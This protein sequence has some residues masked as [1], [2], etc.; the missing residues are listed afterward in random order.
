MSQSEQPRVA[1]LG[2]GRMGA[3]M[4]RHVLAAG[5]ELVVWNRDAAKAE[6]LREAGAQVAGAPAAAVTGRDVVVLMLADPDAVRE[7]LFGP[8]GVAAGAKPGTLVI[9][10]STIGP[11]ASREVAA[12]LADHGVRYV[13]APVAGSVKPATDG[14]LG[15]LAGGSDEDFAAARPFL[16]LW[17]EEGKVQHVGPV[18]AGSAAKLVRNLTLGLSLAGIGEALRLGAALE[19]EPALVHELI[20]GSPFGASF[21]GVREVIESGR[22]TPANFSIALL[23]KDLD[24]CA[25]AAD[26]LPMVDAARAAGRTA[27]ANGYAEDDCRALPVHIAGV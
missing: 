27:I 6:P 12:R 26:G 11:D 21:G 24:L 19:L 5:Y 17:G 14:T 18:G 16:V 13:D 2:L 22:R 1:F 4:A 15:V 23:T 8:D 7:V 25:D 9:D 20:A 3:P 10:A